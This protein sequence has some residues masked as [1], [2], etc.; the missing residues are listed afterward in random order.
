MRIETVSGVKDLLKMRVWERG[1]ALTIRYTDETVYM[2][3]GCIKVFEGTV[4]L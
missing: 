4:T 1:G 3:G 2:T